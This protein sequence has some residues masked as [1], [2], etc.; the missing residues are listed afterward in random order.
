MR[1]LLVSILIVGSVGLVGCAGAQGGAG[2]ATGEAGLAMLD[3]DARAAGFALATAEGKIAPLAPVEIDGDVA[4]VGP[5]QRVP[6]DGAPGELVL[7]RG[8]K[9]DL[10]PLG[11]GTE[12]DP[13]R[14]RVSGRDDAARALAREL[15]ADATAGADGVTEIAATGLLSRL[16]RVHVPD[17]LDAIDVVEIDRAEAAA[18]EAPADVVVARMGLAARAAEHP[19]L[20]FT[21]ADPRFAPL[22]GVASRAVTCADPA[23]GTWTS[24]PQYYPDYGDWYVFTLHVARAA[25]S[26]ALTG[27][28]EAQAWAGG[29]DAA[30]QPDCGGEPLNTRV[31]EPAKGS[32]DGAR[33][34][35]DASSWSLH[36]AACPGGL[37]MGYNPDHFTGL[38]DGGVLRS[39][40]ND[41]GRSVDDPVAFA[42]TACR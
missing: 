29:P 2:D 14:V 36:G 42:H 30:A 16:A 31:V 28:M 23:A 9:G 24:N 12:V 17:G 15:G 10:V 22:E 39:V 32:V 41:G 18:S 38:I 34:A 1:S 11:L 40:N 8:Q 25:G 35:F 21:R 4:V 13:D 27:T 19:E 37:P 33:F 6:L 20:A 7:V 3:G 5:G 26:G